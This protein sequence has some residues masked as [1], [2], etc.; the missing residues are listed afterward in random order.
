MQLSEHVFTE[1]IQYQVR[2]SE[3]LVLNR[4]S[5]AYVV[6][7]EHPVLIDV[8]AGNSRRLIQSLLKE[9]GL[10][11]RKIA[12]L[13]I[14][15]MHPDRL[16]VLKDLKSWLDCPSAGSKYAPADACKLFDETLSDGQILDLGGKSSLKVMEVPGHRKDMLAF[17]HQEDGVLI[18]ADS[19][20]RPGQVP[21]Y[22]DVKST[23]WSIRRLKNIGNIKVLAS[24][25]DDPHK[26]AEIP[27]FFSEAKAY[28]EK[29]HTAVLKAHGLYG[30]NPAAVAKA[31][32]PLL[33]LSVKDYSPQYVRTIAAHLQVIGK[34]EQMNLK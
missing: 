18:S 3:S 26:G 15:H 21:I 32:M 20:P 6:A 19:I 25:W 10:V 31:V 4:F 11:N 28:V 17:F 14:T 16:D 9:S 29:V 8:D 12:K 1:K 33:D 7:G 22:D 34:S 24:S 23:I 30:D 13:L 27:R 5:Y 2:L